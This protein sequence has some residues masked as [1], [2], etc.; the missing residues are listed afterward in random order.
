MSS[1]SLPGVIR[2]TRLDGNVYELGLG[3]HGEPGVET[4]PYEPASKILDRI[5]KLL[6]DGLAARKTNI[7]ES[8]FTVLLNNLGSVSCLEMTFLAG[9]AIHKL[10]EQG[11]KISHSIVGPLITSQDM[12][13]F[14][15]SLV[16]HST[17]EENPLLGSTG[18]PSW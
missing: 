9:K 8:N 10:G 15:L 7:A 6:V 12:N 1:C 17:S 11:I 2:D 4:I 13:G 5:V 3:V 16:S 14:S 18:A